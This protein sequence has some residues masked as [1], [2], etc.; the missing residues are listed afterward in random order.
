MLN[1]GNEGF[2][3]EAALV[4]QAEELIE[5]R[6]PSTNLSVPLAGQ[7]LHTAANAGLFISSPNGEGLR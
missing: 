5:I 1:G 3:G 7:K 4:N 2:E 6:V